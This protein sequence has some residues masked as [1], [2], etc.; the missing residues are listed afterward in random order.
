MPNP[1][2]DIWIAAFAKQY[3]ITL[4]AR[5]K[6]FNEIYMVKQRCRLPPGDIEIR[7]YGRCRRW[8]KAHYYGILYI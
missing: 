3:N 1:D 4:I 6:H 5:H 8:G 7:S 2:N